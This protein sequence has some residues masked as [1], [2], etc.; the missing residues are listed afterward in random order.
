MASRDGIDEKPTANTIKFTFLDVDPKDRERIHMPQFIREG[1]CVQNVPGRRPSHACTRSKCS[2]CLDFEKTCMGQTIMITAW[3][4]GSEIEVP[5]NSFWRSLLNLQGSSSADAVASED[6]KMARVIGDSPHMDAFRSSKSSVRDRSQRSQ[7]LCIVAA[8]V[9]RKYEA[10]RRS[11]DNEAMCAM[12]EPLLKFVHD[13][14][15]T[16]MFEF[17]IMMGA[18]TG[19]YIPHAIHVASRFVCQQVRRSRETA[20]DVATSLPVDAPLTKIAM[21]ERS[22]QY[23]DCL[24]YTSPSPRDS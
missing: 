23:Q 11:V 5:D 15:F 2:S 14:E 6:K 3:A 8:A 1:V 13:P 17:M 9:A 19:V 16:E 22:Y 10:T 24:L 4:F 7:T 18:A 21:L 12:Y 20:Y